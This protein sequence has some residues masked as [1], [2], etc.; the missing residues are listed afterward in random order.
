MSASPVAFEGRVRVGSVVDVQQVKDGRPSVRYPARVVHVHGPHLV[1][2]AEWV[3]DVDIGHMRFEPGDRSI[4]HYWTDRWYSIWQVHR[5]TGQLKGWYA[6][7]CRPPVLDSASLQAVDLELDLWVWPDGRTVR[8]DEDEFER[9]AAIRRDPAAAHGARRAIAEVEHL[10]GRGLPSELDPQLDIRSRGRSVVQPGE[11]HGRGQEIVVRTVTFGKIRFAAPAISYSDDEGGVAYFRPAGTTNKVTAGALVRS[12]RRDR[13]LALRTELRRRDFEL[14]DHR[15]RRAGSLVVAPWGDWFSV[16]LRAD[17]VGD[18]HP[19]VVNIETPHRRTPIGYDVDD[20][21]LDITLDRD[22]RWDLKDADD[23]DEREQEGIYSAE[24]ATAIR[25]AGSAALIAI[26]SRQPP[27][28]GSF[29]DW[30]P[31]PDWKVPALGSGWD[32][33]L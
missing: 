30:R 31:D 14:A 32:Q 10:V 13:E 29:R 28:N 19:Y 4:E 20:L 1:V 11:P 25:A 6:N 12:S 9:S 16:W 26:E 27:F 3:Q 24:E 33:H 22:L 7:V 18:F 5:P 17:D 8:L 21:C 2:A 23:V 15:T